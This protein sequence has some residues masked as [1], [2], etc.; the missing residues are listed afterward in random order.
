MKGLAEATGLIEALSRGGYDCEDCVELPL[1]KGGEGMGATI[2]RPPRVV[3]HG[4]GMLR[5]D[6]GLPFS[7]VGT[8]ARPGDPIEEPGLEEVLATGRSGTDA[9]SA[10]LTVVIE[11]I[12]GTGRTLLPSYAS[13]EPKDE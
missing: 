3:A 13:A 7:R 8:F 5:L 1:C 6:A 10:G 9:Y 2:T 11:F 4:G 12:D